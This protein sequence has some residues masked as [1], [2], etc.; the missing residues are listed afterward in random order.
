MGPHYDLPRRLALLIVEEI[1]PEAARPVAAAVAVARGAVEGR[2]P[3]AELRSRYEAARLVAHRTGEPELDVAAHLL[4]P[5]PLVALD[6]VVGDAT[7]L[8]PANAALYERLYW[9]AAEEPE[10]Q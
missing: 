2:V 9:A 3:F 5:D 8:D 6:L 10:G 1:L 4:H 7:E